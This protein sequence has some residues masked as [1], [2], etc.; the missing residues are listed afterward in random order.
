MHPGR[1]GPPSLEDLSLAVL[2]KHIKA[3]SDD[4][5]VGLPDPLAL[6]LWSAVL[7]SGALTPSVLRLFQAL[8]PEVVAATAGR[9]AD[10]DAWAPPVLAGQGRSWLGDRPPWAR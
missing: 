1:W 4:G 5:L 9:V 3:V 7:A 2:A 8:S 6:R 10:P